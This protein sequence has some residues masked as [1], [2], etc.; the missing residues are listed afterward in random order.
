MPV[1]L[2]GRRVGATLGAAEMPPSRNTLRFIV[3]EASVRL[4]SMSGIFQHCSDFVSNWRDFR[5]GESTSS[6]GASGPGTSDDILT[7]HRR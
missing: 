7:R 4:K 5:P 3:K 1:V 2:V 6:S